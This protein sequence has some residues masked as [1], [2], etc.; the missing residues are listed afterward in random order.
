M[1]MSI[2]KMT[3]NELIINFR[4]F[5]LGSWDSMERIQE[6][7]DWDDSPHFIYDWYQ[8]NWELMVE[9][10]FFGVCLSFDKPE[11]A[12][13]LVPYGCLRPLSGSR[14]NGKNEVPTHKVVCRK[15]G[16]SKIKYNFIEFVTR[17]RGRYFKIAAPYDFV[18]VVD[19]KKGDRVRDIDIFEIAFDKLEF[20]IEEIN[21]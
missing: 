6:Y 5:L 20:S 19:A 21:Q 1:R 14:Y 3:V 8:A 2:N 17:D 18:S 16:R 4:N 12:G 15:K 10:Q 13:T 7:L 9:Q 11:E